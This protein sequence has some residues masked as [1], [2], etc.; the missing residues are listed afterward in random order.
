MTEPT[1]KGISKH[2]T[3]NQEENYSK[4]LASCQT[5]ARRDLILSI[6]DLLKYDFRTKKGEKA[7]ARARLRLAVAS[8]EDLKE[9]AALQVGLENTERIEKGMAREELRPLQE[10]RL[11]DLKK[12]RALVRLRGIK[13]S[14]LEC[15]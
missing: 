9:M 2:W 8:D 1:T 3:P 6:R 7:I 12:L 5:F 10:A 14:D 11:E 13:R 15:R 4:V